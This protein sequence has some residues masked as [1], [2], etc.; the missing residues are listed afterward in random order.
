MG[1]Y[2]VRLRNELLMHT[3]TWMTQHSGTVRKK[4]GPRID[5][6]WGQWTLEPG[7]ETVTPRME[8][9]VRAAS[10]EAHEL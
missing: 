7:E 10:H 8:A 9:Q 6:G 2:S 1:Y 4:P 3:T 5:L